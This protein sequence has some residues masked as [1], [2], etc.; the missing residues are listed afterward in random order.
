MQEQCGWWFKI[1]TFTH[2]T[3]NNKKEE[4]DLIKPDPP[5]L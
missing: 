4:K 3:P 2:E 1:W 5:L